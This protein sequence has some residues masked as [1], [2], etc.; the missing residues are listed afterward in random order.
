MRFVFFLLVVA[1]I[2]APGRAVS[3]TGMAAMQYYVGQWSCMAG[4]IGQP[5]AKAQLTYA[6]D[7]G[8]LRNLI[9]VPPQGKMKRTYALS[10]D[11]T[12]DSKHARYVQDS[13]DTNGVSSIS[14]V[15]MP[16]G[17]MEQWTDYAAYNQKPGH[18]Q[19]VR[20][21]QNMFTV[22]GYSTLTSTKATFKAVCHRAS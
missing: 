14:L 16:S 18:G 20:N 17:T 19:T 4:P 9:V 1:I 2:T 21:N 8:V 11:T 15:T 6:L 13:V 7:S 5:P 12:Y 3:A 10:I 22:T